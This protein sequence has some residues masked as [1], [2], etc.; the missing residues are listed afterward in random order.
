MPV[1]VSSVVCMVAQ[2]V[3]ALVWR[4]HSLRVMPW[5]CPTPWLPKDDR[6]LHRVPSVSLPKVG[7]IMRMTS[8]GPCTVGVLLPKIF[9][10][11][12]RW[13]MLAPVSPRHASPFPRVDAIQ[14]NLLGMAA[15]AQL[16]ND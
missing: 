15:V 8:N 11:R 9:V 2:T 10:K 6:V 16:K 1:P 5:I 14:H 7:L 4:A 12:Y 3:C 13:Y